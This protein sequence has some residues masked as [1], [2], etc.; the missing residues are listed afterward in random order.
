MKASVHTIRTTLFLALLSCVL[1][2]GLGVA[3][4]ASPTVSTDWAFPKQ[5][6]Y[7]EVKKIAVMPKPQNVLLID[8]RPYEGRFV[9]GYIPTAVSLPDSK[10][11][12]MAAEVLPKDKTTRLIFYCQGTECV[13]SHQSAFKAQKLGY[14]N[15][16]VYT[17]GLPDWQKQ[18]GI[19]AVGV[20]Y[21][22]ELM[23][24][25]EAYSLVDS[26]PHNKF[27]EGSIP[28]AISIPD[29][30]FN[31]RK[32]YL[33]Q[34]KAAQLIFF[35]QGYDCVLSHQSAAKA[36]KLGYSKVAVCES[37]YPG[38]QKLY[39][40]GGAI[41]APAD[42]PSGEYPVDAFE[43]AIASGKH[44]LYLVDTRSEAEFKAG[45]FP[46]AIHINPDTLAERLD[47]LPKDKDVVFF[48]STGSR[49]GESYYMA[50]DRFPKATNFHYL[51]AAVKF[52]G[53]NY[54]ITPN[55]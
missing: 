34:D 51:E 22:R 27:V 12:A 1:G 37:G 3:E 6:G 13:L 9:R 20:E 23:Q 19:T 26:R 55:K 32:G 50:M 31:E 25:G 28:T 43:K 36:R 39:G 24:K 48:C 16:Q 46:G 4:A 5:I 14:T 7:D 29:S 10:F 15:V 17:G 2:L 33:P 40:A 47:N 54:V 49:A 18:G 35:C 53:K 44:D 8:S 42:G 38:W 52:N 21:L 30:K 41:G 11:D 45:S